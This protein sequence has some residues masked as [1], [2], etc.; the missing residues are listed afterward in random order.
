M[1]RTTTP[2]TSTEIKAAKAN[3]KD[4]TLQDG[5]GLILLVKTT[6]VKKWRYRYTHPHKKGIR[7]LLGIGDFST[8]TLAEARAK[9]LEAEQLIAK[10]IDPQTHWR[11]TKIQA[12]SAHLNTFEK[13]AR[14]W[15]EIK[16]TKVSKDHAL[17]IWRSL[18]NDVLPVIGKQPLEQLD[19]LSLIQSLQTVRERGALETVR[20]LCQRINEIMQYATNIGLIPANPAIGIKSAFQAPV[21]K[22][23]PTI[24]PSELPELMS[25]IANAS[26]KLQT[27]CL[28][29]WQLHTMVR[30]SEAS[31]V[32]WSEI[33]LEDRRWTIPA[34]RMK[35]N[36]EHIVP[37]TEQAMTI[38]EIMRKITGHREHIFASI[39]NPRKPMSSQTTN[40]ALRRMGYHK[41]LVAHGLRALASTTLNEA[42]FD[43]DVIEAALAHVDS[44]T[45]RR[46]YN[47]TDYLERRRKLMEAWSDHI[48]NESNGNN[49]VAS[50]VTNLRTIGQ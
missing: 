17:D 10:G 46:V 23:Q 9:R 30:P 33:N 4:R 31:N 26:I 44:N 36:R 42:G 20:R 19:A 21:V 39:T 18:E 2:L 15:I 6:G 24:A 29:E 50:N 48:S 16:S 41:K 7:V 28:I 49:S 47:R 25:S 37:L 35:K 14:Q 43:S 3:G 40:M 12:E 8:M 45:V 34:G 11:K 13:V 1:A 38:L 27:R 32:T 5:K 22:N